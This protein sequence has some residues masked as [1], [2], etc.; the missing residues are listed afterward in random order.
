MRVTKDHESMFLLVPLCA[1]AIGLGA[2]DAL[3]R[4]LLRV[5]PDLSGSRSGEAL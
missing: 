4:H 1:V 2:L 5:M 3:W